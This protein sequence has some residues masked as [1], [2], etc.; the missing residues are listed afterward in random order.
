MLKSYL[1][2]VDFQDSVDKFKILKN[3]PSECKYIRLRYTMT[4]FKRSAENGG[5][6]NAGPEFAGPTFR[7]MQDLKMQDL[8]TEDHFEG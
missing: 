4:W 1:I 8:N 6:E 3:T 2:D 7:K 5:P